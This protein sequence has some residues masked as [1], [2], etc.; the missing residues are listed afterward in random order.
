MPKTLGG[1]SFTTKEF[2][3]RPMANAVT[4]C[5]TNLLQKEKNPLF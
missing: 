3:D 4:V 1:K 2:F 5:G